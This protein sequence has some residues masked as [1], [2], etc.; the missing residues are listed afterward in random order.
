MKNF[1]SIG[2]NNSKLGMAIPSINLP[3]IKTCRE[4]A[5]CKKYCYA[6]KGNFNF[7]SV[8]TS[9]NNNY[10]AFIDNSELYFS[11]IIVR[12]ALCRFV[13]WHSSGDIINMDYLIG[14]CKVARKNKGTKYLAFTKKYELVNEYLAS[15]KKIPKNLSIVF[16]NWDDFKC[17]NP[18]NLP[19]AYV[20]FNENT[21][22]PENAIHCN[23]KCS[24]CQICWNMKPNQSVVFDK[25]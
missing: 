16:S 20:R 18:F 14:M 6:C 12:T 4:N 1:V 9:V 15:G 25:H 2:N 17:D 3:A 5:P 21:D 24:E 22:I 7:P 23:N 19:T 10:N 13:R 8:K 11:E